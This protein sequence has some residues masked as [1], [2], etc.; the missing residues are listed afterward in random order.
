MII[1]AIIIMLLVLASLIASVYIVGEVQ[2]CCQE[3]KKINENLDRIIKRIS[4]LH[5]KKNLSNPRPLAWLEGDES[6]KTELLRN[7]NPEMYDYIVEIFKLFL[8]A[9]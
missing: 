4:I 2:R 6:K 5:N 3:L 8:G 1:F 7:T 9:K